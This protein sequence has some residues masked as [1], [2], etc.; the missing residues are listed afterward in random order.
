MLLC[1]TAKAIEKLFFCLRR[2]STRA[3]A[4]VVIHNFYPPGAHLF[5]FCARPRGRDK[6]FSLCCKCFACSTSINI[7]GTKIWPD[8]NAAEE[9]RKLSRDKRFHFFFTL[10]PSLPA[11]HFAACLDQISAHTRST[12]HNDRKTFFAC[13]AITVNKTR[14]KNNFQLVARLGK[15]ILS[16]FYLIL[17]SC[18]FA[19]CLAAIIKKRKS[20]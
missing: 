10:L 1:A 19:F 18:Y 17:F 5:S 20:E 14:V 8:R 7:Y 13:T 9:R 11:A 4:S 16:T 15:K 12:L 3:V 6:R 2:L